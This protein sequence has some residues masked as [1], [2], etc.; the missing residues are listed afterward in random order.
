MAPTFFY[1][2]I[3]FPIKCHRGRRWPVRYGHRGSYL[4]FWEHS[5]LQPSGLQAVTPTFLSIRHGRSRDDRWCD[6]GSVFSETS[7]APPAPANPKCPKNRNRRRGPTETV[8]HFFVINPAVRTVHGTTVSQHGPS[9]GGNA[10]GGNRAPKSL[11]LHSADNG[12]IPVAEISSR[13]D[14]SDVYTK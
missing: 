5:A 12:G 1:D 11:V 7:L 4:S 9:D 8:F 14:T 13:Y 2:F 10:S 6:L 3:F